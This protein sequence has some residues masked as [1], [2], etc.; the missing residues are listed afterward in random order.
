MPVLFGMILGIVL[1][2]GAAFA[3]DTSTGRMQNGLPSSAA[4]GNAPLVNWDVATDDW[5]SVKAE[6]HKAATNME[7]GWKG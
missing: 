5:S 2:I 3:Y 6:L 1:T 7:R 4:N